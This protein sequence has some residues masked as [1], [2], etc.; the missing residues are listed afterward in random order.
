MKTNCLP[1]ISNK[2]LLEKCVSELVDELTV[3]VMKRDVDVL[4]ADHRWMEA[5]TELLDVNDRLMRVQLEL[6][7]ERA[8]ADLMKDEYNSTMWRL[9]VSIPIALC[10]VL[11]LACVCI[12]KRQQRASVDCDDDNNNQVYKPYDHHCIEETDVYTSASF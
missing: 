1:Q 4:N 8:Y 11:M 2:Q 12:Q 9:T 7:E 5:Q 10:A 6:N 3:A